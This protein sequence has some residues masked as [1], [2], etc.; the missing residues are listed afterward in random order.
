MIPAAIKVDVT[1]TA[2]TPVTVELYDGDVQIASGKP[3]VIPLPGAKL[4]SAENPRLYTCVV[5]TEKDERR[6]SFGVRKLEWS[7]KVGLLVN[8]QRVLLR[9]GCIHHDHGRTGCL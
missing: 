4:W 1:T 9:G 7:A 5:K 3:G 6:I 2:H 8:G